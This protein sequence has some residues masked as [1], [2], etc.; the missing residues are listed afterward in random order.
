MFIST[1][2]NVSMHVGFYLP[3]DSDIK[4]NPLHMVHSITPS[5]ALKVIV[6]GEHGRRNSVM[7]C[8]PNSL[9]F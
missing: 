1:L 5:F 3:E 2:G 6:Y 4:W 8:S 9:I 7:L